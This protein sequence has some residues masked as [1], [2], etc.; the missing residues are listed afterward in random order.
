MKKKIQ[1][2]LQQALGFKRYLYWFAQFKIK[3]FK[4]DTGE[5]DFFYFVRMLKPNSHVLDIGS[6]IGVTTFHLAKKVHQGKVYSFEPIPPN[7]QTLEKIKQRYQLQNVELFKLAI[8]NENTEVEMVMPEVK[9]VQMQGLSHVVH[10]ELTDFN[11]G[12]KFKAPLR[13]LD[14]LNIF[15]DQP[16]D[17]IKLDI[18]NFEYFAL[19]GGQTLIEQNQPIIYAELWEND[20]RY[21]CFDLMKTIG[22]SI[23]VLNGKG[24]VSYN[25]KKHVCQNFFFLPH[26]K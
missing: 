24:L 3:T 6:N 10:E 22:Y 13:K 23:H 9:N 8:G 26:K 2:I 7:F 4:W 16:I 11:Y 19:K 25:A 15:N 1:N 12:Q 14:S 5:K 18:E 20:N 17:G 21:K